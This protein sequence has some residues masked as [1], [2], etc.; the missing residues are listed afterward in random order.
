[1]SAFLKG[2]REQSTLT[3]QSGVFEA[4]IRPSNGRD[5]SGRSIRRC[6]FWCM[7]GRFKVRIQLVGEGRMAPVGH[8]HKRSDAFTLHSRRSVLDD[9]QVGGLHRE[10]AVRKPT[11]ESLRHTRA[12]WFHGGRP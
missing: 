6:V 1:M 2:E 8:R 5:G 12:Q 9:R 7:S 4:A 10:F 3:R 11:V